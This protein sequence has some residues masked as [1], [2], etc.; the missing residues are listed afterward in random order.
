M[1][2]GE[3][4]PPNQINNDEDKYW[5]FTRIQLLY[6]G[7]GLL[8]GLPGLLIVSAFGIVILKILAIV[9][10]L[11]FIAVGIAIGGFNIPPTKYLAGG[12]LRMDKYLFRKFKK[13]FL[14]RNH[15]LYTKNIDRDKLVS[16]RPASRNDENKSGFALFMEDF[17]SM[18]GGE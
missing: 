11:I 2:L 7:A 13:K 16:Y 12:G 4:R 10:T 5:K 15:I 18:F 14:K 9:F 8:L 17:K 1:A 3:Y 6:G